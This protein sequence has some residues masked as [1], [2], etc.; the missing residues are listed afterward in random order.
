MVV[1]LK[2]VTGFCDHFGVGAY[3]RSRGPDGAHFRRHRSPPR[4]A[5]RLTVPDPADDQSD[6][7]TAIESTQPIERSGS[8]N[9]RPGCGKKRDYLVHRLERLTWNASAASHAQVFG[10]LS[11]SSPS[12]LLWTRYPCDGMNAV[13]SRAIALSMMVNAAPSRTTPSVVAASSIFRH[14]MGEIVF[15]PNAR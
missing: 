6:C 12:H 3:P 7:A 15:S 5:H 9:A 10:Q 11:S 8:V 1:L 14:C 2:R 13:A 4:P